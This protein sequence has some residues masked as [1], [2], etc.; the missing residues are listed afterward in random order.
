MWSLVGV[1]IQGV[2]MERKCGVSIQGV[3]MEQK[4]GV[5]IQGILM[6]PSDWI[7]FEGSWIAQEIRSKCELIKRIL[8]RNG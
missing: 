6:E 3:L 4:I 1:S 2:L 5:S 7:H 8:T